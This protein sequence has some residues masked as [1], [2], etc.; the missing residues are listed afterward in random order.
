MSAHVAHRLA[1]TSGQ[2]PCARC[3]S[4]VDVMAGCWIAAEPD[5]PHV[6]CDP[7]AQAHDPQGFA[8]LGAW[9][10]AAVGPATGRRNRP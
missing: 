8:A 6:V 2:A 4:L 7:C 10:R 5:G 1:K 9:R 3:L